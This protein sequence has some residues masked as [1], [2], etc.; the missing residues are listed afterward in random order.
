[1]SLQPVI[2]NKRLSLGTFL[3]RVERPEGPIRAGQCYSIGS[4]ELGVNREYSMYSGANDPFLEFLIR[5][6]DGGVVSPFLARCKE[7][8]L[9]EIAG[10]FGE[11]CLDNQKVSSTR[12]VFIASGTGIA[13]FRSFVKTFS[14]LNYI[15]YHGVRY[16]DECYGREDFGC[17]SYISAISRP[18]TSK[19][20]QR[21]TDVL[22]SAKLASDSLYYLCGNRKM[23]TD[24]IAILRTEKIPGGSI[25]TESFF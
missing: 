22:G 9:L 5:E 20:G 1:M 18:S 12:F 10:P 14:N 24:V 3:L 7:G 11:F 25:Y 13:P 8:D 17:D 6:V 15:I 2:F 21:V 19:A 16:E 4:Q 23:I